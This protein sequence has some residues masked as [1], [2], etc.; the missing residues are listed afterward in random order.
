MPA[1]V[2][3]TLNGTFTV[4]APTDVPLLLEAITSPATVSN[5]LKTR[6]FRHMLMLYC[7]LSYSHTHICAHAHIFFIK[8]LHLHI[9]G[10]LPTEMPS[11]QQTDS[12]CLQLMDL[13]CHIFLSPGWNKV[14]VC[15]YQCVWVLCTFPSTHLPQMRYIKLVRQLQ[16]SHSESCR[17]LPWREAISCM[18]NGPNEDT[19]I[20]LISHC[21]HLN[22]QHH[23]LHTE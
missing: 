1:V 21:S 15:V 7:S 11:V 22:E 2:P 3:G 20:S 9:A 13:N 23:Y 4:F 18:L 6:M 16:H 5:L 10:W 19:N 14:S 17:H 8:L 12:T